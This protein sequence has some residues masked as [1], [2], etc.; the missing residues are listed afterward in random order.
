MWYRYDG[1]VF[2][3]DKNSM[4]HILW[5]VNACCFLF[6]I[7]SYSMASGKASVTVGWAFSDL[8]YT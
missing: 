3:Y 1:L 7:Y 8:Q 4:G 6:L 2:T 5:Q